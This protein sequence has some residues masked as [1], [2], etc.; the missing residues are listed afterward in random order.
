MVR[1]FGIRVR[2]LP[3]KAVLRQAIGE[4][5]LQIWSDRHPNMS[6]EAAKRSLG[7]LFL[8]RYGGA[9]GRLCYAMGGKPDLDN[10][11][12]SFGI[13][14]TEDWVFC[15]LSL[16]KAGETVSP[17]GLDAESLLRTSSKRSDAFVERWFSLAERDVYRSSP[18]S[19]TFLRIWTGKEA[20]VKYTGAG[21]SALSK[22]D[23]FCLPRAL[24]VS[25]KQY[26]I[27]DVIL[28]L[29]IREGELPPDEI[30]LL[31]EQEAKTHCKTLC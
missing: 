7:G 4:D 11:L 3:S 14:H 2:D 6:G 20:L 21:L 17:I 29:C 9:E 22:A 19:E 10:S 15:A 23:T 16:S 25:L 12:L 18:T 28:T 1:I 24:G 13:T 8:L 30:C 31:T 27:E 26:A 5:W